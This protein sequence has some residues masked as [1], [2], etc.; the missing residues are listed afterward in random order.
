[1]DGKHS[2]LSVAEAYRQAERL[3]VSKVSWRA[4]GDVRKLG[5]LIN[6]KDIQLSRY[7]KAM[8]WFSVNWPTTAQWP[9]GVFRPS[10]DEAAA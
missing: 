1:M 4:F 2:L 7:E 6:G 5:D 9:E 8:L 3:S 10:S